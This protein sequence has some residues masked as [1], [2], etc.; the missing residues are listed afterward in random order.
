[1]FSLKV[2]IG[3]LKAVGG[4]LVG[5]LQSDWNNTT[6]NCFHSHHH[7]HNQHHLLLNAECRKYVMLIF[8][9]YNPI[10]ERRKW[11][12]TIHTSIRLEKYNFELLRS[13]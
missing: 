7:R 10:Y 1:M 12:Y 5:I 2:L 9:D 6:L 13:S 11:V 3:S 4:K 8:N